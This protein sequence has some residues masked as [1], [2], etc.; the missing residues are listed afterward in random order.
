[1]IQAQLQ[2]LENNQMGSLFNQTH[3]RDRKGFFIPL[4]PPPPGILVRTKAV[5]KSIGPW[6]DKQIKAQKLGLQ[7]AYRL[8]RGLIGPN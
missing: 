3:K 6:P 2:L 4:P 8:L 1:M 7:R 5:T